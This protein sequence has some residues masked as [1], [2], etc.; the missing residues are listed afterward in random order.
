MVLIPVIAAAVALLLSRALNSLS[1]GSD[2]A[3]ALGSRVA[4]T[5]LSACWRSPSCAAAPPPWSAR[6]PLSA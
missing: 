4:R 3:T 6:S 2:T 5:Q 1:L